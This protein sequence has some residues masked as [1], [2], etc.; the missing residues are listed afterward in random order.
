M[1]L[2]KSLR[3]PLAVLLAS[4]LAGTAGCGLFSSEEEP[5]SGVYESDQFR[6]QTSDG[7]I[8]DV[9]DAGGSLDMTLT[10][11][12]QVSGRLVVPGD[13]GA[14]VNVDVPFTGSYQRAAGRVVFTFDRGALSLD[15][16][17]TDEPLA[18]VAW[19]FFEKEAQIAAQ[20]DAYVLVLE[21]QGSVEEEEPVEDE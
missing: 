17:D 4:L 20:S 18:E 11:D 14:G 3:L 16:F 6:V 13:A 10:D 5:L 8:F 7:A 2:S 15:F 12:G 1:R 21:K 19:T 9:G